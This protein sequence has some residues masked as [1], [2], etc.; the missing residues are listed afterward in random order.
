MA[1]KKKITILVSAICAGAVALGLGIWYYFTNVKTDPVKVYPFVYMGMTEY[2]GDS[3]ESYGPVTSDNIQTVFLSD[4]QEV[5]EI[6]V[7]QGDT[8]KKGDLLMRFDTTLSEIALE[9]K[10]LEVEKQKL[11]LEDAKKKLARINSLKPSQPKQEIVEVDDG[12]EGYVLDTPYQIST[13]QK[14]DG[15]SPGKALI[16]WLRD[17]TILRTDAPLDT[18]IFVALQEKASEYRTKNATQDA[19]GEEPYPDDGIDPETEDE[20]SLAPDEVYAHSYYVVFK[21]TS[22]NSFLGSR[23]VWQGMQVSDYGNGESSGKYYFRLFSPEIP[24]HMMLEPDEP[25]SG[26]VDSGSGYTA[27]EIA[28]MR[29]EQLK[30]IKDIE[31][32]IQLQQAE[33]KIMQAEMNDGNVYAK[34]DGQVVSLLPEEEARLNSQPLMK[35]SGGGGFYVQGSV[36]ELERDSLTIG[37]EVTVNDW[38][39]G[40]TYT[41]TV[42][43]VG[44]FP[45]SDGYSYGNGNPN[46]SQYPFYVFVDGSA[47][48]QEGSYVSVNYSSSAGEHGIYLEVPFL[49]QENGESYVYLRGANGR[50][51][52]RTVATGKTVW[53]SHVE[54]LSGIT[55]DDYLAFPYGKGV[56]P[57]AQTEE[58]DM[59]DLYS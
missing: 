47:N 51:E 17:D 38:N 3:R 22:G 46:A 14:Y 27:A 6:L 32:E 13:N 41:G 50:L 12:D 57:G 39:T 44:E 28:Q 20:G 33:Y 29:R 52:K 40:M 54:I 49:R 35:V 9:R 2:W 56:K 26:Y 4:T 58:G 36:S 48:L 55:E 5:T 21:V 16:C 7:K 10:R 24:D 34:I 8:V 23:T 18:N 31:F 59:Q 11:K 1:K 37:Q 45:L 25:E 53:G 15:S 42:K 19:S 30:A 43:S